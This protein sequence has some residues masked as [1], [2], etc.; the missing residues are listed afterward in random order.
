L[1]Q[2]MGEAVADWTLAPV[3]EAVQALRQRGPASFAG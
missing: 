3:V 2:A 1:E